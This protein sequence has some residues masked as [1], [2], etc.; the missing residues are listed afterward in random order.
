MKM[1]DLLH[2]DYETRS[3]A[4]LTGPRS[5]GLHNYSLDPST[6]VL[7]LGWAFGDEPVEVWE[8][9]LGPMPERLHDGFKD[10][11]QLLVAFNSQFER[12]ITNNTLHMGFE[13]TASRFH[14]PQASAR[15]LSLPG[16]LDS[17]GEILGLSVEMQKDKR[18]TALLRLF[19]ELSK[20][21]KK[22]KKDEEYFFA[23]ATT[24]PVEWE[25]FREYCRQD[26]V[27]EREVMHRLMALEV[28]PLPERERQIW[29]FDQAVNDRG[30]PVDV[31]FVKSAYLLASREK[32]EKIA[33]NNTLTGLSGIV[34]KRGKI[35]G[36]SNSNKQMLTWVRTQGYK[37]N[38][39]RKEAVQAELDFNTDLTPLARQVL[40]VRKSGSSTTYKKLSA[41]LRQV[42]F[43]YRL[44]NQ[45]L[46]M[47]SA[48]CGRWSGNSVQL[49]NM[50]RPTKTFEDLKNVDRLREL[51]TASD[52]AGIKTEFD[53][54]LLAVKSCIR[55][56][57]VATRGYKFRVCDLNAIETRVA[58]W[59]CQCQPLLNV[60]LQGKDPYLDFAS[61]MFG[62]PYDTLAENIHSDD[63]VI[64]AAAKLYRQIAKPGVLGCV[65]RLSGGQLG[66]NKHGDIVKQGM[67][68]YAAGMGID[69]PCEFWHETVRVFRESYLE[70]PEFWKL[71][72]QAV[73]QVLDGGP[74]FTR[75]LGPVEIDKLPFNNRTILRIKLPSGRYLHYMDA[76]AAMVKMP[77]VDQQGNEVFKRS[78]VYAGVNQETKRWAS[79]KTH[80]G[81]LL[82]NIV[83]GIA[84][85]VLAESMLIFENDLGMSVCGHV[86]DEAIVEN[87]DDPISYGVEYMSLIMGTPILWAP[88]LPLKADG[89]EALY[90]HK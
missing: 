61:K 81:K 45:F 70:I 40:N 20:K 10:K 30:M 24:N 9:V 43:D 54:V 74:N 6:E 32:D 71:A 3:R 37:T 75:Q 34:N 52:Y 67:W 77:W 23:D 68:G 44:R 76:H 1:T 29:L 39:L 63:P 13:L 85:D 80:G 83:Q 90:Y 66:K 14:D 41:I 69:Q 42:S 12:Y 86:H 72:E 47:G 82:E 73:L 11:S 7:M 22:R 36:N 25:E 84:R 48:R 35:T 79:V 56:S 5:V 33:E 53:S 88:G 62:I 55:T 26:V 31:N 8:P 78:L 21:H 19:S 60:F 64:K 49:H 51:V 18:G 59:V 4:H 87:V 38:S 28:F 2:I 89:F 16:A 58:A 65:Y 46:Y 17:V 27:T 50:A 57:F 15:Y